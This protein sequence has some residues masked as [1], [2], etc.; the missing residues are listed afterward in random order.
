MVANAAGAR[1]TSASTSRR[2]VAFITGTSSS[3]SLQRAYAPCGS[4]AAIVAV[5]RNAAR[6]TAD[7]D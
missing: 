6:S 7:A 4:A 1:V 3:R 5:R 2:S